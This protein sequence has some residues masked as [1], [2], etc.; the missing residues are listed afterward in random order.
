M[1]TLTIGRRMNEIERRDEGEE[2][3]E[4]MGCKESRGI[5]YISGIK[6]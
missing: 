2:K 1:K 5:R 4:L 3:G 6:D